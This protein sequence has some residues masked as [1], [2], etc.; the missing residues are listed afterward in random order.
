M[1]ITVINSDKSIG[2]DGEFYSSLTFELTDSIHAI[3]WYGTW[4]E[5]E[6]SLILL[7]G[8]PFKPE[9]TVITTFTQYEYL[10]EVWQQAKT[11]FEL[12]VARHAEEVRLAILAEEAHLA[13]ELEAVRLEAASKEATLQTQV[14]VTS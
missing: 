1:R 6:Y 2:I 11:A 8:Q 13:A 5:I 12:E 4:G 3:Q 10:I 7:N 9:N 14:N